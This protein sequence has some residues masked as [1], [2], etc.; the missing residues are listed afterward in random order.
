MTNV[1]KN[2]KKAI[3]VDLGYTFSV[4]RITVLSLPTLITMQKGERLEVYLTTRQCAAMM[5]GAV[6][7]QGVH[8]YGGGHMNEE[9][10]AVV[11]AAHGHSGR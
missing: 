10:W 8:D 3:F 2:E 6:V 1:Y 11:A 9:V 4:L 5:R 7:G